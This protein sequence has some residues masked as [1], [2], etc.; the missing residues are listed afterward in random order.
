MILM[1]PTSYM[2]ITDEGLDGLKFLTYSRRSTTSL[3]LPNDSTS[4]R[5]ASIGRRFK[6]L[7][8]KGSGAMTAELPDDQKHQLILDQMAK[9]PAGRRGPSLIKEAIAHET[10][11]H[12]TSTIIS[13]GPHHE[14]SCDGH[15]KLSVIGFPIWAV[16]DVWSGR[17][18]GVW[19]VPNNWYMQTVAYL[20]LSLV[21]KLGGQI[22]AH[23]LCV[24]FGLMSKA[25]MPLQSTTDCGSE[26]VMM[27]GLANALR[28]QFSPELGVVKIGPAHRFLKSVHNITIERGWGQLHKQWGANVK[29]FWEQGVELYDPTVPKQYDLVQWLWLRLIQ[30]ELDSFVSRSNDHKPRTT[31]GKSKSLPKGVTPHLAYSFP[32]KYGATNCLQSIETGIVEGLMKEIG[33]GELVEFVPL[34]YAAKAEAVYFSLGLGELT[35]TNI[36]SVFEAMLPHM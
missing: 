35:L 23:S 21:A 28:E 30:Q 18:L 19:V 34:A 6:L 3:F 17:W 29:I 20:Y 12:L 8:L 25:G 24:Q 7:G 33:G 27:Y 14:W 2:T 15:D 26:T 31:P 4:C 1:S 10:G 36:W 9:D 5:E 16:R 13:L 32:E 11:I 22:Q